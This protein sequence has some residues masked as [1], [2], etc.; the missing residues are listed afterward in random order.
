MDRI[1]LGLSIYC[2]FGM[3]SSSAIRLELKSPNIIPLMRLANANSI[4]RASA[5]RLADGPGIDERRCRF[6]DSIIDM[7]C[8]SFSFGLPIATSR[9]LASNSHVPSL[10]HL[11]SLANILGS[12]HGRKRPENSP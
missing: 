4:A 5:I 8:V 10:F 6:L 3:F 9:R 2:R 12:A 11:P 1:R 7:V